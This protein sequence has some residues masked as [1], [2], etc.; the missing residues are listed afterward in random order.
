M[1]SGPKSGREGDVYRPTMATTDILPADTV[2]VGGG[3]HLLVLDLIRALESEEE[4]EMLRLVLHGWT[5]EQVAKE[6]GV[7]HST[8]SRR[9]KRLIQ[10]AAGHDGPCSQT[11]TGKGS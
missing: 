4:E 3:R 7:V 1:T 6:L 11:C 9:L 5:Q 8:I 10:R 2:V